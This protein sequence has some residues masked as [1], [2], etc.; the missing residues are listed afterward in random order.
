MNKGIS[1]MSDNTPWVIKYT[2]TK[3]DDMILT[4][5]LRETFNSFIQN[6]TINNMTLYGI[7]G[8][9]KTTIS[10]L[11][12]EELQCK[13]VLFQSCSIDGSI[14]MVKTKIKDFCELYCGKNELKIIILDEAD[15]LTQ[16][17]GNNAGA[18]MAL[19]NI[20]AESLEDTRFIL[21]CNYLDRI[22]PALQSRCTPIK[23]EFT[24]QDV[25]RHVFKILTSEN[26]KFTKENLS[27]F[28]NSVVKKRFPDIR[29]IIET[30]Q[31]SCQSGELQVI[32]SVTDKMNDELLSFINDCND[33]NQIR[34]YLQ[35]N[36]DKF[37]GDYIALAN[38]LFNYYSFNIDAML[39]IADYL[40]K[41]QIVL[42]KEIQFTAMI[43]QLKQLL[44]TS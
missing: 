33:I 3:L 23:L 16:S 8:S 22:I 1:I 11:L 12:A 36:E 4:D 29:S 21:T 17:A 13:H 10:K 27:L 19:R 6:R 26:I 44:K 2:P 32:Q 15:S 28:I 40:Y 18:Q 5:S 42:D 30:L 37:S 34:L 14:D 9:G 38:K 31:I 25:A 20:I 35:N 43:L 7:Q 24:I 39:C 41:M